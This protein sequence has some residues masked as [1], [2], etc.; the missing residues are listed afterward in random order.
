MDAHPIGATG[1]H[2]AD[3]RMVP[4]RLARA[5]DER[6]ARMVAHG[7]ERAFAALYERYAQPLYRYCRSITGNDADAQDALQSALTSALLAL[8]RGARDAPLRPWL[9]R[10]AHNEAISVLRRR[11]PTAALSDAQDPV[12]PSA[13][14]QAFQRERLQLLVRD[15]QQLGDRQRG[16][17]V[18]RELSGLSH[19]DIAVALDVSVGAAKQAI[20][21]ARRALAEL[22]EGRAMPCEEIRRL[23]SDG[24]KRMLRGR[25][26]RAHLRSCASCTAFAAAIPER[27][28]ELHALAPPLAPVALA[29]VLGHLAAAAGSSHGG[30]GAG[31]LAF[32][33]AGK[34]AAAAL[35][36]KALVGA[37]IVTGTTI[38]VT[39]VVDSGRHP[40]R[41]GGS[42][43]A[44]SP[45]GRSAPG[46]G[47]SA[48]STTV[49]APAKS[50]TPGAP[51]NPAPGN[52]ASG[53]R[54]GASGTAVRA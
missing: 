50:L 52:A 3:G 19:E 43:A 24:D 13:A 39:Q 28:A 2:E 38:G 33:T 25:R 16:A 22:E 12:A 41:T 10:I 23:I 8:R 54:H 27:R 47:S 49:G 20:F 4:V 45:S 6:L 40:H 37:A 36:A 35:T 30:A 46:V 42:G 17:L 9:F 34:S 11:R 7:S 32:G 15:L 53:A 5:R 31:A 18:M 1:S 21:E 26:V 29:S 51:A 44:T 48:S 14:E